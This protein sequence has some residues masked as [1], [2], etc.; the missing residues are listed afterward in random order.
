MSPWLQF[1]GF[2]LGNTFSLIH[3]KRV[4]NPNANN[5][6]PLKTV[7]RTT[8]TCYIQINVS[9]L[10]FSQVDMICIFIERHNILYSNNL[11]AQVFLCIKWEAAVDRTKNQKM[12]EDCPWKCP[13]QWVTQWQVSGRIIYSFI[14]AYIFRLRGCLGQ[15]WQS[16][17]VSLILTV[18]IILLCVFSMEQLANTIVSIIVHKCIDVSCLFTIIVQNYYT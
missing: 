14:N 12:C 9:F 16:T 3:W 5:I 15:W 2:L 1:M 17:Q 18:R 6:F 11:P 10:F 13:W 7:S 4:Q 8:L